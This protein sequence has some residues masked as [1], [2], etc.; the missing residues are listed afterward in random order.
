MRL[1]F[2]PGSIRA[3][4]GLSG[5]FERTNLE[6]NSSQLQLQ[7]QLQLKLKSMLQLQRQLQLQLELQL[8]LVTVTIVT[9]YHH[10]GPLNP[11]FDI[12]LFLHMSFA[13][14]DPLL[15]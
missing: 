14:Y 1:G 6:T 13:V 8:Q 11:A 9:P 4:H 7:L 5:P 15:I 2:E 3:V 12:L 10:L